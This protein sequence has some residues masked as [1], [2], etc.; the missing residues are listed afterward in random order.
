MPATSPLEILALIAVAWI[1]FYAASRVRVVASMLR[2]LNVEVAPFV[3]LWRTRRGMGLV[4]RLGMHRTVASIYGYLA[5][6][7]SV[8]L[9]AFAMY[10]LV[11]NLIKI[12]RP[13]TGKAAAFIP[14]IPGVTLRFEP[15]E[16]ALILIAILVSLTLHEMGHAIL[17]VARNV[18]IRS[19]GV[20]LF[21]VF[22]AGF[23]ELDDDSVKKAKRI[24]RLLVFSAGIMANLIIW[25]VATACMMNFPL[26]ISPAYEP[27]PSG[28]LILD[29][30]PGS[31]AAQSG[32][33]PG[34]AIIAINGTP[35]MN[36]QGFLEYMAD[37]RPGDVVEVSLLR[38]GGIVVVKLVLSKHPNGESGFMGVRV[39]NYFRPRLGL[40]PL[41]PYYILFL[42]N[43][44]GIISIS[45]AIF[46]ALP[47]SMLDGD[48]I[49]GEIVSAL[50]L[51]QNLYNIL[52][53][54]SLAL[55]ALNLAYGLGA[56]MNV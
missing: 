47:I 11:D 15:G 19:V 37:T 3:V 8:G 53:F 32:L 26:L 16:L 36:I 6:F 42:L 29:V 7:Y 2:R 4:E 44:I 21:L 12:I 54:A 52:R 56:F 9:S 51:G 41:T 31:P 22:P 20:A 39:Y 49:L 28:V 25:G 55:L 17:A 30:V 13:E 45:V 46:N 23:V 5:L 18:K 40:S 35:T 1:A 48:K 10:F 33:M 14:L 34:D 38:D 43:W 27:E 24:D 50:G